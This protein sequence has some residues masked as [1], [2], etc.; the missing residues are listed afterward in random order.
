MS[1]LYYLATKDVRYVPVFCYE[2]HCSRFKKR[3]AGLTWSK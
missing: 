3:T 1:V 2:Q